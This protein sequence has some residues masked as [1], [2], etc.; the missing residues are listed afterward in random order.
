MEQE[1]EAAEDTVTLVDENGVNF[2]FQVVDIVEVD[3]KEYALLLPADADESEDQEV[4]VMRLEGD[5]FVML[6]DDAEFQNVV[7]KLEEFTEDEE[8]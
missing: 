6:E 8:G 2:E 7:K 3:G 4:L 1:L 5:A